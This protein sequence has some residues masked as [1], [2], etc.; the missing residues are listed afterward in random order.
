MNVLLVNP[1]YNGCAEIPALGLEYI[2]APLLQEGFHVSILDLDILTEEKAHAA[3]IEAIKTKPPDVVGVT[4]LSHSHRA[5]VQVCETAKSF[6]PEIVT[7]LGGMHATVLSDEILTRQTDVDVIVRGEGEKSFLEVVKR[8]QWNEGF[9]DV[10]GVSFRRNGKIVHKDDRMPEK[11][12]DR[13][14]MPSHHL[15]ENRFYRTRSISS[16]RGCHHDCTFCSIQSQYHHVVRA[17]SVSNLM[18]E[19]QCL[20]TLGAKRIM[21]TDDDFLFNIRRIRELCSGI[22][23]DGFHEKVA[24]YAE[25]RIDDIC[26]NPLTAR[27]LSEAGFR[28]VYIG[29]ESGSDRILEYYRKGIRREDILRGVAFCVEQNLTPVVNFIILGPEDDIDSIRE[30]ISLAKKVFENGAE[31]AYTE[32]LIPYPGTPVMEALTREGRLRESEG[33]YF[34]DPAFGIDLERFY[35]LFDKAREMTHRH[36]KKDLY[37]NTQKPY[38]ELDYFC[39]LLERANM[40]ETTEERMVI[41]RGELFKQKHDV[42]RRSNG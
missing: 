40:D 34:F 25:A 21:F 19:I 3:L 7:V 29:A 42:V 6:N 11:D 5:A 20:I 14:L 32:T 18:E 16:S 15:V 31:I 28:G 23:K 22:M 37:Y 13:L 26:R 8:R 1:R 4:S 24:F 38:F 39:R 17:R 27:V 30:T 9:E 12:L 41:R 33:S 35:S 36:H 2:A 10:E